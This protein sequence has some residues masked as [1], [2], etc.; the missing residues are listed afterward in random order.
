MSPVVAVIGD[1]GAHRASESFSRRFPSH[2]NEVF[3]HEIATL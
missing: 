2:P 1:V 3:P